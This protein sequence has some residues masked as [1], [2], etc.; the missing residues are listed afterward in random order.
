MWVQGWMDAPGRWCSSGKAWA[1]CT[2]PGG[3]QLKQAWSVALGGVTV[4]PALTPASQWK[5][6]SLWFSVH[7]MMA[8][9]YLSVFSNPRGRSRFCLLRAEASVKVLSPGF[10]VQGRDTGFECGDFP[11]FCHL[12]HFETNCLQHSDQSIKSNLFQILLGIEFW[13][14]IKYF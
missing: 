8:P 11:I 13:S 2:T 9:L 14:W 7:P 1:R 10:M 5:G 6:C 3:A 12:K 4:T